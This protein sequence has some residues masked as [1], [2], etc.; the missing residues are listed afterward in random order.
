MPRKK[1]SKAGKIKLT[2][3]AILNI[4]KRFSEAKVREDGYRCRLMHNNKPTDCAI[5]FEGEYVVAYPVIDKKVVKDEK[6]L[7][8]RITQE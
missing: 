1:T 7:S 5:F 8:A 6:I 3:N 2:R 4:Y